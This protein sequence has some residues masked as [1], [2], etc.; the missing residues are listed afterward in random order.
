VRGWAHPGD[1]AVAHAAR[2]HLAPLAQWA[3]GALALHAFLLIANGSTGVGGYALTAVLAVV[4]TVLQF[5]PSGHEDA[6][7]D[8]PE[9]E[10]AASVAP[11]TPARPAGGPLWAG[12]RD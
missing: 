2:V 8:E 11:A 7:D 6:E 9:Q 5:P 1:D 10:P 4:A 12:R 3:L